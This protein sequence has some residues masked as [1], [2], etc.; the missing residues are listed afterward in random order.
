MRG[1]DSIADDAGAAL[2]M[3]LSLVAQPFVD[4]R[5]EADRGRTRKVSLGHQP[6]AYK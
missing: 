6:R 2:C 4:L 3:P 5:A 1:F